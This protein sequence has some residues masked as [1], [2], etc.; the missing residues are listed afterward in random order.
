MA[1]TT[2]L[3]DA[4]FERRRI[5]WQERGRSHEGV[6]R[7]RLIVSAIVVAAITIGA[8]IAHVLLS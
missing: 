6:V 8:L 1:F 3:V 7:R 2:A 4:D 5:A